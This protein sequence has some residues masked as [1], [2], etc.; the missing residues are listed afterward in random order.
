MSRPVVH[1]TLLVAIVSSTGAADAESIVHRIGLPVTIAWDASPEPFVKGYIVHIGTEPGAY[2]TSFDVG[3]STSFH[4]SQGIELQRYYF[5]VSAYAAGGYTSPLSDMISVVIAPAP[6]QPGAADGSGVPGGV[7]PLMAEGVLLRTPIVVGNLVQLSWVAIGDVNP[8]SYT[9]EAGTASG[10]S[11]LFRGGVGRL[12]S[13]SAA[14]AP[15]TYFVRVRAVTPSESFVSN[16]VAFAVAPAAELGCA[17]PPPPPPH[18]T[19]SITNGVAKLDW[20]ESPGADSYILQIGRARGLVDI[21]EGNIGGRTDISGL[22]PAG[23]AAYVRI[24]AVN[25]C[26][27]SAPSTEIYLRR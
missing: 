25:A 23:F 12:E 19:S 8:L 10:L 22:L 7:Q 26:G 15:G 9:L 17:E 21:W 3:L 24:V 14:I 13:V 2:T 16:E 18:V 1:I 5:A 6:G 20:L 27:R 11:N 4:F